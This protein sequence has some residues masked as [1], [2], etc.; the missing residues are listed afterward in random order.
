MT[1]DLKPWCYS[2]VEN[3]IELAAG[4]WGARRDVSNRVEFAAQHGGRRGFVQRS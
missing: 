1:I 4:A 3:F 2:E